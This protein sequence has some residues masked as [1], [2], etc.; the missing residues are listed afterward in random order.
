MNELLN[1]PKQFYSFL[2]GSDAEPYLIFTKS[3][4]KYE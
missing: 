1:C 3:T 2:V 4:K